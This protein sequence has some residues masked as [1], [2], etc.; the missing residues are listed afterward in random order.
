MNK[1]KRIFCLSFDLKEK[2]L[3]KYYDKSNSNAYREIKDFMM[4]TLPF[5][6]ILISFLAIVGCIIYVVTPT[7]LFYL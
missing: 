5:F 3:D 6:T 4:F 7:K 1:S 2:L